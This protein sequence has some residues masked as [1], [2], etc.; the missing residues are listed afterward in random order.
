MAKD[1]WE[2]AFD[3]LISLE[4][5]LSVVHF[6]GCRCASHVCANTHIFRL[7]YDTCFCNVTWNIIN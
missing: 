3:G 1:V 5:Y 7:I 6:C 2:K 4:M